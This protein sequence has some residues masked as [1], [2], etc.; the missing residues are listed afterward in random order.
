VD[1]RVTADLLFPGHREVRGYRGTAVAAPPNTSCRQACST[2]STC[3]SS[4]SAKRRT[5]HRQ[6]QL[7]AACRSPGRT[8]SPTLPSGWPSRT[9][10]APTRA[11]QLETTRRHL[12]TLRDLNEYTHGA[13]PLFWGALLQLAAPATGT[14]TSPTG[15]GAPLSATNPYVKS[16]LR[17]TA[18]PA[19]GSAISRGC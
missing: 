19:S 5:A 10:V 14:S 15:I 1:G 2:A 11:V 8:S 16:R 4:C 9:V 13:N 3:R 6:S 7:P 18:T 17:R 12:T